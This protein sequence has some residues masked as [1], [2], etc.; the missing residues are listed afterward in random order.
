M[1]SNVGPSL[2]QPNSCAG[3]QTGTDKIAKP[4]ADRN[5]LEWSSRDVAEAGLKAGPLVHEV[6][7]YLN[8][9]TLQLAVMS[10]TL[11]PAVREEL[12]SIK[13]H[14]R[15][16]T[17]LIREWQDG[18]ARQR[19]SENRTEV[20]DAIRCAVQ[21]VVAE[22]E[23]NGIST[24]L[25]DAGFE[26][27]DR[28]ADGVTQIDCDLAREPLVVDGSPID[29]V[30]AVRFLVH[31]ALAALPKG[32]GAVRIWTKR[33]TDT[34]LLGVEDSGPSVAAEKLA[35]LFDTSI[36]AREGSSRLSLAACATLVRRRL[37]GS[38]EAENRRQGGM[39]LIIRMKAA[40]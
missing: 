4:G 2:D 1:L 29:I 8:V 20:N 27:T 23:L 5:E 32:Q 19:G 11:P 40:E 34:I 7:N 18:G 15:K 38:I 26:S 3:R 14:S 33:E 24:I 16:L 39:A 25:N 28:L 21:E 35:N 37:H 30:F 9:V 31:D 13:E 17:S 10:K 6:N 22:R 36:T 12:A